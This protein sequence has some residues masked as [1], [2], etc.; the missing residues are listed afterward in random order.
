MVTRTWN[1]LI[2]LWKPQDGAHLATLERGS[3]RPAFGLGSKCRICS[4]FLYHVSVFGKSSGVCLILEITHL[5]Q[6]LP[7]CTVEW[8]LVDTE[9][10][11][12]SC[13]NWTIHLSYPHMYTCGSRILI[14]LCLR[15]WVNIFC[16]FGF[17]P[18]SFL[19]FSNTFYHYRFKII[20]FN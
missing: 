4:P 15:Y 11:A 19:V 7:Y 20:Y 2:G 9:D 8:R 14:S 18:T 17:L 6:H 16:W 12:S 5:Q 10:R 1:F 3:N 13:V